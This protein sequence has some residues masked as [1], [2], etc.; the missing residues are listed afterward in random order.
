MET[1]AAPISDLSIEGYLESRAV[2][3]GLGISGIG[4]EFDPQSKV[5]GLAGDR[6]LFIG[7]LEFGAFNTRHGLRLPGDSNAR[8]ALL[9]AVENGFAPAGAI[10][11]R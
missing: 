3:V 2:P 8:R 10:E 5:S 4:S 6:A 1:V 9:E 11:T 7:S